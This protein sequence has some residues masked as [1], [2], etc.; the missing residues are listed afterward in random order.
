MPREITPEAQLEA[1]IA[2]REKL[3]AGAL[4]I[5]DGTVIGVSSTAPAYS[6]TATIAIMVA[7]IGL[8]S[9]SAMII[10]FF[11]MMG[12]AV[13]FYWL[14][15]CI[16]DCGASYAWVAKALHPALGFVTGW[17]ILM[18]DLIVMVSLALVSAQATL[19]LVGQNPTNE[20]WDVI[21]G[22]AWIVFLTWVVYRGIQ[23][24]A[25][26]QWLLLGLEFFIVMAFSIWAIA[27]VYVNHPKGAHVFSWSWLLPWQA[28]GGAPAVLAAVLAAVFIYWG[29]DTAANVNEE[30]ED[31]STVPGLATVYSTFVLLIIYIFA[32]SAIVMYLPKGKVAGN[33]SVLTTMAQSLAGN[34]KIWYVMVLAVASS[35]AAST[36]TTILPFARVTFSMARD[37]IIPKVFALVHP[38]HLTPW[39]STLVIGA[40]SVILYVVATTSGGVGSVVNDA[41]LAIGLL[42]AFYYGLTG[43]AAAWYYRRLLLDGWANFILAG[44]FPLAGGVG[45]FY[46]FYEASRT[47]T[48]RQFWLAMGSMLLGVP[49]LIWSIFHNP[50]FY[51]QPTESAGR[52]APSA[53]AMAQ[54]E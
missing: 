33:A 4:N 11:P 18:A 44:I 20:F 9:P 8:W 17:V 52:E 39:F 51:R 42:I 38:R 31:A 15:R 43:I 28:P 29:W 27:D 2:V 36:Q 26:L 47:L 7:A 50:D 25:K 48:I 19:S 21:L 32:S 16:P 54:A 14:N 23:V 3:R 34:N 6:L 37:R 24:S 40:A 12:V 35:A 22:V 13:G 5:V 30:T 10:A 41:V 1:E 49:L 53:G 46:I 45:F